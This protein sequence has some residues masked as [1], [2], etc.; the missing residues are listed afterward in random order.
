MDAMEITS[1]ETFTKHDVEDYYARYPAPVSVVRVRTDTGEEGIGQMSPYNADITSQVFHRQVA[2]HALGRDPLKIEKLVTDV[3][4]SEYKYPWSYVNRALSGLDTALW[5]IKAKRKGVSVCELLGGEPTTVKPYA[6]SMRRDITPDEEAS[7][8]KKLQRRDGY[9]A[10]KIRIGSW[11]S[12]GDDE[13]AW[14]GRTEQVVPTVRD[15]LGDDVELFVDANGTY[16]PD[17]AISISE[18]ILQPNNVAHYEEPCPFW[19]L[20]WTKKVRE[21]VDIPVAGGEQDN[22]LSQWRRIFNKPA[23]DIAQP[24]VCY[25]GGVHRMLEVTEMAADVGIPIVPHSANQ[26]LVTVFTMHVLG[27]IDATGPCLELTIEEDWAANMLD[28]DFTVEN[29]EISIPDGD[30]W[31]VDINQDWLETSNYEISTT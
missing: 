17:T 1:L 5:D 26:S 10:F 12:Q 2:P 7:R 24:D 19:E 23:V 22:H 8:L 31:G 29:G 4:T 9:E 30:G 27:A 21:N 28:T 25:L 16:S 11:E 6:S 14:S 13:D 3:L 18:D 20:E 15:A